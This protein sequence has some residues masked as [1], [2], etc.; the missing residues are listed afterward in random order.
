MGSVQVVIFI[1][2]CAEHAEKNLY[3]MSA[4]LEELRL[5]GVLSFIKISPGCLSYYY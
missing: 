1:H 5:M 2:Y 4:S 3:T